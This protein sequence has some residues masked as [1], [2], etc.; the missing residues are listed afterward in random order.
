MVP[1]VFRAASRGRTA[2]RRVSGSRAVVDDGLLR[3]PDGPPIIG[4]IAEL[5]ALPVAL[6]TL[7]LLS[8]VMVAL[9]PRVRTAPGRPLLSPA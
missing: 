2:S 7:V 3:L 9:A 4:A 5:T 6:G 8:L 1:V